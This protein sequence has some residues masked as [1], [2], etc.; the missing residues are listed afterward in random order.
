MGNT[1]TF[2]L[3]ILGTA[4]IAVI[5]I[6]IA[7]SLPAPHPLTEP[8]PY[9]GKEMLVGKVFLDEVKKRLRDPTAAEFKDVKIY[10][11]EEGGGA[12]CGL[13]NARTS[14]DTGPGFQPFLAT[15]ARVVLR[16]DVTSDA[17]YQEIAGRICR[18]A[19]VL[20]PPSAPA[21]PASR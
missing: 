4:I 11:T 12:V 13:V 3:P 5:I 2:A 20:R 15:A 9:F 10:L 14:A 21:P 16:S 18:N 1:S 8:H 7:E 6:V 19:S 17:A